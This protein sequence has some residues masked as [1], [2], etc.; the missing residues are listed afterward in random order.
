MTNR[1][2]LKAEMAQRVPEA[3]IDINLLKAGLN[4]NDQ[5][6]P[7]REDNRKGIDLAQAGLLFW[8]CTSAKSIKELDMQITQH[9]VDEM[10]KLRGVL[11]A[12]WGVRDETKEDG[13]VITSVSDLW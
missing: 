6:D 12:R 5:Y 7:T 9:D 3:N 11:L 10:L 8:M 13:P 2:V 4:P 1:E